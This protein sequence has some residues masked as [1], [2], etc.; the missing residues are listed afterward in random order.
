MVASWLLKPR[1]TSR[2][3]GQE[4]L[5]GQVKPRRPEGQEW[6]VDAARTWASQLADR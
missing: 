6:T 1:R 3:H 4:I 5:R 2:Q